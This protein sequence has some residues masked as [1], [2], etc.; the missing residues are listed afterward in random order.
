MITLS[1]E[2]SCQKKAFYYLT[3]LRIALSNVILPSPPATSP[4]STQRAFSLAP[5]ACTFP[6][7]RRHWEGGL[8]W[9]HW[10][11]RSSLAHPLSRDEDP[12]WPLQQPFC[13]NVSLP[14]DWAWRE[15]CGVS[16]SLP[17]TDKSLP[18]SH[19]PCLLI[20][21]RQLLYKFVNFYL[22]CFFF[23]FQK[24]SLSPLEIRANRLNEENPNLTGE[25]STVDTLG[26]LSE[27]FPMSNKDAII[28]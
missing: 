27:S 9:Q 16:R 14:A 25:A 12:N 24:T 13:T 17:L 23:F 15:V 8:F 19:F 20:V 22:S 18:P 6:G 2:E 1:W 3:A 21:S 11:Y 7:L 4:L 10:V 5:Q 26:I 28:L